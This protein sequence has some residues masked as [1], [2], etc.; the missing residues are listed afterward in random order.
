MRIRLFLA[1]TVACLS[2]LPA[3]AQP[4]ETILGA[5]AE[6]AR[7]AAQARIA[8]AAGRYRDALMMLRDVHAF[9]SGE[10]GAGHPAALQALSNIAALQQLQ[11]DKDG[12]LPLALE[13]AGGLERALGSDHVETLNAIANLAQLRVARGERREAEPLLRRVLA[14]RQRTLGVGD[15][16]TLDALL[17]LAVFLNRDGRLRE[18][19]TD[20]ERA[21]D[22]ARSRYGADSAIATD[23]TAA[24]AAAG[25][26]PGARSGD[27]AG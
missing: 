5:E 19:R 24:A 9:A 26:P 7:V 3:L 11:G 4:A 12:A 23:L 16:T 6:V 10:L 21:A 8:F 2:S 13:A 20:L 25:R 27:Q 18:I 17:E 14:A 22:T 15:A 1:V